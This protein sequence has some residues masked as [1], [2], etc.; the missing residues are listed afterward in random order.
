ML[1]WK[2]FLERKGCDAH[3]I[4]AAG[5]LEDMEEKLGK[6]LDNDKEKGEPEEHTKK[7]FKKNNGK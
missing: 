5:A 3:T 4:K 6:D 1:T 7:V 2:T